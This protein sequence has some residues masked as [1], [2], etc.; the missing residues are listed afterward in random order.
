M[1]VT[2]S[3]CCA[4]ARV[5]TASNAIAVAAR[6]ARVGRK[7]DMVAP[8]K[9]EDKKPRCRVTMRPVMKDGAGTH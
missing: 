6:S 1:A 7:R 9:R 8:V 3:T 2:R 4:E 5:E